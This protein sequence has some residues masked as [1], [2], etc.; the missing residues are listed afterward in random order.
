[1][2][3]RSTPWLHSKISRFGDPLIGLGIP[4]SVRGSPNWFG[5]SRDM[6]P[7]TNSGIPKSYIQN[8]DPWIGLGIG[9]ACIPKPIRGSPNH[10]SKSGIPESVWGF[11]WQE[12]PNQ[13]CDPQIAYLKRGSPNQK[14][15]FS[16][17]NH[18]RYGSFSNS[19]KRVLVPKLEWHSNRGPRISL[20]IPKLVMEAKFFISKSGI[21]LALWIFF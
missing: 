16:V 5:D 3:H 1:M 8:G 20:G 9:V 13:K 17:T 2:S 7:Q 12:S 18:K 11:V 6:Y 19:G 4:K 15:D 21:P 10:I 14:G